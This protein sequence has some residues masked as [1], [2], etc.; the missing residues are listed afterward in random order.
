VESTPPVLSEQALAEVSKAL[1]RIPSGLFVLT[2]RHEDRRM[3]ILASLVQQ[4][5]FNPPMVCVA[6]AKGRPIM[7]LISESRRFA[8]CQMAKGDKILMRKFA[9]PVVQGDDPFLG[10]E[11]LP[12]T[13]LNLPV[14]AGAMAFLECE[15]TCHIDVDGDHDLFIGSVRNG[16]AKD[17][18][19]FVHLRDDGLKY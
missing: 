2:A 14:L 3:G 15:V 4:V 8:V 16:G 11:L 5:C 6:I 19:P 18:D 9:A 1:G 7:P 17:G 13:T 12:R 10:F